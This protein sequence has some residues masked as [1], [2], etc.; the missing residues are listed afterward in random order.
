MEYLAELRRLSAHCSFGDYLEETFHNRLVCG[1][2]SENIQ[3]RLLDEAEL[4]LTKAIEIAL[5][6]EAA[7]K[8]TKRLKIKFL[9]H[10]CHEHHATDVAKPLM[11]KGTANAQCYKCGKF[12]H[13]ALVCSSQRQQKTRQSQNQ[14]RAIA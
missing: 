5:G 13:I 4:T 8:N 1:L 7:E 10:R 9:S 11:I 12:G 2:R 3:K 14:P 6:M